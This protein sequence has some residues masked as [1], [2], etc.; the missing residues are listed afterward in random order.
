MNRSHL[1]RQVRKWY[2][3]MS[4]SAIACTLLSLL[5]PTAVHIFFQHF[6]I[7]FP[8]KISG[9][10]MIKLVAMYKKREDMSDFDEHYSEI[11]TPLVK[12]YPGLR[13]LE[14]TRITGA[15]IGESK[16]H[17]M[18]AMYFD[19]KEAMDKALASPEGKAV[20]KDLM[21]F[22]ADIV[23]IFFGEVQQ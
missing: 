8:T 11:H 23:M 21:T 14:V 9:A 5:F 18:A 17:L 4:E 16:Y 3:K 22:A 1:G 2:K 6:T 12:K 10:L 7:T 13:K 19:S 20:A 15:P